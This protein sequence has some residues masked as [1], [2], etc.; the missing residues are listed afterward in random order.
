MKKIAVVSYMRSIEVFTSELAEICQLLNKRLE[1]FKCIL[2]SDQ[3][4]QG[5]DQYEFTIENRLMHGTKYK[6][7]KHVIEVDDSDYFISIDNDITGN[8][9]AISEFINRII[10]ENYDVAWGK[11]SINKYS[12]LIEAF[13]A[14]DKLLSH[15]FIRPLLWKFNIGISVPG[16]FFVI[17]GSTFK[18]KLL[19]ADTFLDDLALGLYIN[20]HQKALKCLMYPK[21]LGFEAPN[22]TF[23]GLWT[24]RH[25]WSLG[26]KN[27]Y[28]HIKEPSEKRLLQIH[29]FCYHGLW[30][31]NYLIMI[32]LAIIN[33]G[34]S[35]LYI[36]IMSL[37]LVRKQLNLLIPAMLYLLFFPIFHIRWVTS[38]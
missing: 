23:K 27:I 25:R 5:L 38:L 12:N 14:V 26:Y 32:A 35:F 9:Q 1:N 30:V 24:Q 28:N 6:K 10:D 36:L 16:Q 21:S 20:K 34:L 17:K 2:F 13:V 11:V 19:Q 22:N 33:P 4:L 8:H 3:A 31:L 29:G 15:D 7:I 37:I 18:S